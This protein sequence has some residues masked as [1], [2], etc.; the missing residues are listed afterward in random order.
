MKDLDCQYGPRGMCGA[1]GSSIDSPRK[2]FIV[3][4]ENKLL[5]VLDHRYDSLE[6]ALAIIKENP[7][8]K[9]VEVID[10]FQYTILW[11]NRFWNNQS[12]KEFI[13]CA[14]IRRLTSR[15]CNNPYHE[16]TNDILDIE[17]GY[18]HHDIFMR[19]K[20]EVSKNPYDQ[21]FYTSKGRFVDRYEGMKLAIEAGQVKSKSGLKNKES[22]N[23]LKKFDCIF[24]DVVD[25]SFKYKGNKEYY[26]KYFPLFSEDL[27]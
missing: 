20:D 16:G 1:L 21:G 15:S 17:I 27:Y 7:R 11:N 12:D 22:E 8:W 4:S 25:D 26:N 23:N 10:D 18:R 24:S 19:F 5:K 2:Y 6:D 3:A 14:A 13:I 9:S